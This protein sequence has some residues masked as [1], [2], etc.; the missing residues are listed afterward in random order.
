MGCCSVFSGA[1]GREL[2][3]SVCVSGSVVLWVVAVGAGGASLPFNFFCF[4][5]VVMFVFSFSAFAHL[6]FLFGFSGALFD[7]LRL[8]V[9]R[10][11]FCS[12]VLFS[13]VAFCLFPGSSMFCVSGVVRFVLFVSGLLCVC[14]FFCHMSPHMVFA[15]ICVCCRGHVQV[16]QV[17]LSCLIPKCCS[18]RIAVEYS[19]LQY[20]QS[21]GVRDIG[22]HVSLCI[23]DWCLVMF[24]C[25]LLVLV[26]SF[27][28]HFHLF[29]FSLK[30]L[31]MPPVIL[32][33]F[34]CLF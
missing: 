6:C 23:H 34:P 11:F 1:V 33:P 16:G 8:L 29:S 30:S 32:I 31:R 25:L 7:L 3:F 20:G 21:T 14:S 4:C 28:L 13:R 26:R 2:V 9:A 17:Y 10:A 5:V 24:V 22:F 27:M 12:F 15:S 18:R 19:L